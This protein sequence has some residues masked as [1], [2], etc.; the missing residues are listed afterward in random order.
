MLIVYKVVI[1]KLT[2]N[3]NEDHLREIFAEYGQIRDLDM[4]MNRQCRPIMHI[5]QSKY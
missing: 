5:L 4:P 3:V 1:E 2:K